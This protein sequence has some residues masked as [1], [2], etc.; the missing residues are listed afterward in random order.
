VP[1][2]SSQYTFASRTRLA[3]SWLNCDP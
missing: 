2:T 1:G 3:M